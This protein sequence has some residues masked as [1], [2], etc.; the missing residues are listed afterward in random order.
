MVTILK[1]DKCKKAAVLAALLFIATTPLRAEQ[2]NN[3][4]ALLAQ[5]G[6][7]A[8]LRHSLAPG[9]GDPDNFSVTDCSTQR[10]LNDT[11]RAQSAR[12]G[13]LFRDQG[14]SKLNIYSSQWCRCLETAELIDLGSVSPLASLNSF[15]QNRERSTS[16]TTSLKEWIIKQRG[17]EPLLLVTHQVNITALSDYYP[18]SGEIVM[19][20]MSADGQVTVTGT[21]ETANLP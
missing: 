1:W 14:Y 4:L 11:G 13:K 21:L 12:I 18:A 2:E 6:H 9:T 17:N 10:N 8:L 16:Q 7:V 5:P 19:I 20:N 3:P 15:F